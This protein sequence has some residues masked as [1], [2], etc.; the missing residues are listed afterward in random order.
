MPI[1]GFAGKGII[2]LNARMSPANVKQRRS[3][4]TISDANTRLVPLP[5]NIYDRSH[6]AA[7]GTKT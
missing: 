2:G 5:Q 4:I 6:D 1:I 7:I 3:P